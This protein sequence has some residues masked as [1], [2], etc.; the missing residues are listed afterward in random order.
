LAVKLSF[1][2]FFDLRFQFVKRSYC[3]FSKACQ[4]TLGLIIQLCWFL[5]LWNLHQPQCMN[6]IMTT[7]KTSINWCASSNKPLV[8]TVTTSPTFTD[9]FISSRF[10]FENIKETVV[11]L[12][13]PFFRLKVPVKSEP[14]T[15]SWVQYQI[16]FGC[17]LLDRRLI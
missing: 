6:V 16:V 14:A 8:F 7:F 15:T 9:E 11:A 4:T 12:L 17:V 10:V 5:R 1:S 3:S 13:I 2:I